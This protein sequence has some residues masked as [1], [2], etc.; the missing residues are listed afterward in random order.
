MSNDEIKEEK[1]FIA[2]GE[3]GKWKMT[4]YKTFKN[5][6]EGLKD[7]IFENRAVKSVAQFTR[8]SKK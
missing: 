6:V 8:H 2:K 3:G 7:A 5:K 1:K 4:Q